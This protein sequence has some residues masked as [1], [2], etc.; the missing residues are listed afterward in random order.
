MRIRRL[1]IIFTESTARCC[2]CRSEL[3]ENLRHGPKPILATLCRMPYSW[4]LRF[5]NDHMGSVLCSHML[6]T[7]V[8]K[9]WQVN[10]GKKA[11]PRA[12]ENRRAGDM[13]LVYQSR[14]Q[15]LSDRRNTASEPDVEAVCRIPGEF[16][17]P[18]N[19]VGDEMKCSASLH[20]N[21]LAR[22][23][24]QDKNRCVI[25]RVGSPPTPPFVIRPGAAD[26]PEHIAPQDP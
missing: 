4:L 3:I 2:C 9:R 25:R 24:G 21:R 18:V 20:G 7:L 8:P 16:Q 6:D 19:P 12:E 26:G 13:H 10:A 15:I 17:R 23:V 22:V 11:F 5:S 1:S 14:T